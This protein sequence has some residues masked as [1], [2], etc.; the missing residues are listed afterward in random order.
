MSLYNLRSSDG[1][2]RITKFDSDLNVESSYLVSHEK[3]ECPQFV[4]RNQRCRHLRMLRQL[5]PWC[6]QPF[7]YDY[8]TG[9]WFDSEGGEITHQAPKRTE[10]ELKKIV[11]PKHT[12][13]RF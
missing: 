8:E 3:C 13:R 12:L 5:E 4:N 11:T 2:F 10:I 9:R 6:D 7:F 1:E